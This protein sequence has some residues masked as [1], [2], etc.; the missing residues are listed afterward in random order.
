ME[1]YVLIPD[2]ALLWAP[3]LIPKALKEAKKADIIY[4]TAPPYSV[5]MQAALLKKITRKKLV[6]D[7]KDDWIL[8]ASTFKTTFFTSKI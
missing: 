8:S 3:Y 5:I 2:Y 4:A 6:L 1:K 7:I